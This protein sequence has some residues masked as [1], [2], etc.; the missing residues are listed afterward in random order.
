LG[1]VEVGLRDLRPQS[2]NPWANYPLGVVRQLVEAGVPIEGFAARIEG[3]LPAG[4]GLASSAALEVATAL[5]LLKLFP[6]ELSPLQI[7]RLCQRAEHEF[8][9][10]QSGLLDQVTCIFGRADHAVYFDSRSEEVRTVPFPSGLALVIAESG[11]KRELTEGLYNH[12][13]EETYAAT[14]ALGLG[15]L[16]EITAHE[17]EK[18]DLPPL[19]HRRAAHVVG[20]NDRVRRAVELLAK[21]EGRGFGALL[22]ESHESSRNN[23]ENSTPELDLLVAIAHKLPGVLGARLTGGGFGGATV[24]LCHRDTA[25][26]VAQELS[27]QYCARTGRTPQVF[28]CA[29][30]PG[31]R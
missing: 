14:A 17:L 15:A 31:A 11:K 2:E 10:V 18:R 9:G 8:V 29:L 6:T 22:F 7:A 4:C 1:E 3:D 24:T 16:R 21:S 25:A 23:F 12:R 30:A 26:E 20:E 5:L 19:L 28:V 27:H 13:R